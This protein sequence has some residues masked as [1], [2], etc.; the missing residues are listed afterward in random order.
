MAYGYILYVKNYCYK[1]YYCLLLQYWLVLSFFTFRL[2]QNSMPQAFYVQ[3]FK[4]KPG[5]PISSITF[6]ALEENIWGIYTQA[7]YRTVCIYSARY[8]NKVHKHISCKAHKAHSRS[9]TVYQSVCRQVRFNSFTVIQ[10]V[11]LNLGF[12]C[13]S[14]WCLDP[15][16]LQRFSIS[17]SMTCQPVGLLDDCGTN[18]VPWCNHDSQRMCASQTS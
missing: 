7:V 17:T 4:R 8:K 1:K 14:V 3:V 5:I 18:A 2:Q 10:H 12:L 15:C 11:K 6:R 16:K 9:D 13:L